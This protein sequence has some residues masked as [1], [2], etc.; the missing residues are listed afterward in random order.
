M[1]ERFFFNRIKAKSAGTAI[2]R[3]NHLVIN[4]LTDKTK[5]P[6]ALTQRA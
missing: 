3:Q 5:S 4:I 2:R 6:L 1:V